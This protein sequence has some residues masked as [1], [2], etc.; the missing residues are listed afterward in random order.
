M[1]FGAAGSLTSTMRTPR[2][3]QSAAE[4][5][6]PR[7]AMP[8]SPIALALSPPVPGS[9]APTRSSGSANTRGALTTSATTARTQANPRV[10]CLAVWSDLDD[11]LT[12]ERED[13]HP[14]QPVAARLEIGCQRLKRRQQVRP[15]HLRPNHGK[16]TSGRPRPDRDVE[17]AD[18]PTTANHLRHLGGA[19]LNGRLQSMDDRVIALSR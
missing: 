12:R 4:P 16:H 19:R 8:S 6:D 1:W 17:M 11:L 13:V 5:H 3:G 7:Y 10:M 2:P 15:R 18:V 9:Y 14:V